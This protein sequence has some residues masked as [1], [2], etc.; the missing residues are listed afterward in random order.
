[1]KTL[2]SLLIK[3]GNL[4][5]MAVVLTLLVGFFTMGISLYFLENQ[6][7]RIIGASLGLAIASA[8]GYGARAKTLGLEPFKNLCRKTR[9]K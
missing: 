1:M 6:N 9:G 2:I 4:T 7:F 3:E 5:G 8:G